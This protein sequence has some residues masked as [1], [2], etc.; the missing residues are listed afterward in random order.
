MHG[1]GT[2]FHEPERHFHEKMPERLMREK[3]RE[4]GRLQRQRGRRLRAQIVV[5][6]KQRSVL[7]VNPD[8]VRAEACERR[9]VEV[10]RE[11][12]LIIGRDC[13]DQ[14][15][16]AGRVLREGLQR[17]AVR[18]EEIVERLVP[19]NETRFRDATEIR[20]LVEPN[21]SQAREKNGHHRRE[22]KGD[23]GLD[24][25]R[26]FALDPPPVPGLLPGH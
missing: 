20:L 19:L 8:G 3:P 24:L 5:L 26:A 12:R 17:C 10:F 13:T 25:H 9:I 14:P 6:V 22:Q 7:P 23:F 1:A 11:P 2:H 18:L 4:I 21:R 15:I 16:K